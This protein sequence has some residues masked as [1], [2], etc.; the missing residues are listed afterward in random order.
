MLLREYIFGLPFLKQPC[1]MVNG[2]PLKQ[3]QHLHRVVSE[4]IDILPHPEGS[5]C[6]A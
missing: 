1:S 2:Q 5:T 3:L 6:H 4:A